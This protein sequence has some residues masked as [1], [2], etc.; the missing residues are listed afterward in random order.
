MSNYLIDGVRYSIDDGVDLNSTIA[1]I[2]SSPDHQK[3]MKP[4]EDE[5]YGK[6]V[7]TEG[8]PAVANVGM[9]IARS[10]GAGLIGAGTAVGTGS[11]DRGMEEF[12]NAM[13]ASKDA[14][15]GFTSPSA[16]L[17]TEALSEGLDEATQAVGRFSERVVDRPYIPPAMH[18]FTENRPEQDNPLVRGAG[19]VASNFLPVPGTKLV[20][21]MPHVGSEWKTRQATTAA[22]A[23]KQKVLMEEAA[24]AAKVEADKVAYEK[25]YNEIDNT[26]R[27]YGKDLQAPQYGQGGKL[28]RHEDAAKSE[29]PRV[30]TDRNAG[31]EAFDADMRRLAQEFGPERLKEEARAKNI[32]S[33]HP[34][35]P[36]E[37]GMRGDL[38][39][40]DPETGQ[41]IKERI[42]GP[43]A[44]SIEESLESEMARVMRP[45]ESPQEGVGG[46]VEHRITPETTQLA[47]QQLWQKVPELEQI[48]L[49][50]KPNSIH[51]DIRI[52]KQSIDKVIKGWKTN[53]DGVQAGLKDGW[54][55][56]EK[57]QRIVAQDERSARLWFEKIN[58]LQT[59]TNQ[60][61][62]K[63]T[64]GYSETPGTNYR[65]WKGQKENHST[66]TLLQYIRD[67]SQIPYYREVARKLLK[68]PV[69]NP[70]FEFVDAHGI[71][72]D[73]T[74]TNEVGRAFGGIYRGREYKINIAKKSQGHESLML[75]EAIHAR[76]HSAIELLSQHRSN[77][78]NLTG[79]EH[80]RP[81]VERLDALYTAFKD[82]SHR[83]YV[84]GDNVKAG[85]AL[86]E[87]GVTNVHE[88]IA[89]GFTN[90]HFQSY[91]ART[92]LPKHIRRHGWK[93]YWDS[94]TATVSKLLGFTR[95][96]QNFLSELLRAGADIME[97]ADTT[98][99]RFWDTSERGVTHSAN[100]DT[101]S[102]LVGGYSLEDF[103]RDLETKGTKLAPEVIKAIYEKQSGTTPVK[104]SGSSVEPVVKVTSE[105]PGLVKLQRQMMETRSL[106]ELEPEILAAKDIGILGANG[107]S[108]II[109]GDYMAKDH[110]VLSWAS[111]NINRIKNRFSQ[112]ANQMLHGESKKH[113][114]VGSYNFEWSRLSVQERVEL[115]DLGQALNNAQSKLFRDGIQAKAR[116]LFGKELTEAQLKSYEDRLRINSQVLEKINTFLKTEGKETINELPHYWSPAEFDGRFLAI[117]KQKDGT[118][119]IVRGS[120]LRP[121]EAKLKAAFTNHDIKIVERGQRASMD[122]D[123][124]I[125]ILHMLNKELRDPAS[126]AIAEGYRRLGFGRH[127]LKREGA[128]GALGTEGGRKG[129][130]RYEEVSEKYIRQSHE[131]LGSRELDKI[132]NELLEFEPAKKSPYAQA[133]AL[134][135]IDQARGGMNATMQA[136]SESVGK[137]AAG[138][139]EGV[140]LG[141]VIPPSTIIRDIIRPANQIK[142]TLL[143][144]F[145]NLQFMAANMMQSTYAIPKLLGMGAEYGKMGIL[146][147]PFTAAKAMVKALGTMV[148]QSHPDIKKLDS[149]GTFEATMK[150]DW[151][152]YASDAAK[153]KTTIRDHLSGMSTNA[154]IE[155]HAVRKPAA[156]MFLEMLRELGYDKV[157][158]HPDDIY[159]LT[160]NLTEDYM[161]SMQRHKKPHIFGRTGLAGTVA[162]P[163]QSFTT[164]WVA[165]LREYTKQAAKT[166]QNPANALPLG[167]FLALNVLTAGLIGTIGVKEWDVMAEA[168]N[169]WFN[170]DIPTG[171][172]TILKNSKS[173]KLNFGVLSDAAGVHIGATFSAPTM[174]GTGAPGV[175]FIYDA[176]Q[177]IFRALKETGVFGE[178]NKPTEAQKRDSLKALTPRSYA[179]GRIEE[180]YTPKGAPL[181]T[182]KG[183]AGP[184]TRTE[185]DKTA[186]NLGM[187]SLDEVKG[188]IDQYP[189]ER[190]IKNRSER[191]K[192]SAGLAVDAL[193]NGDKPEERMRALVSELAKDKYSSAEIRE[194]LKSQ[195]KSKVTEKDIRMMGHGTT[196]RQKLIIQMYNEL[197]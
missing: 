80:L 90:P 42:K 2:R 106:K 62:G 52:L 8:L 50:D 162:S 29:Y 159:W 193:L 107:I 125:Q 152:T 66:R 18:L 51:N 47:W 17:G 143:L 102:R 46:D 31:Q 130:N 154:A 134:E 30:R 157:A 196:T 14:L 195:L 26:Q 182:Q 144:G 173:D 188:K 19:E 4:V 187:Y 185:K 141:K 172:E 93:N 176:G 117:I 76:T 20:G 60:L 142:S 171:T 55:D 137:V 54:L 101:N 163:L 112:E 147:T 146:N 111:S 115:N 88:F 73:G 53:Q 12:A 136:L 103:K 149:I 56:Q 150:Y 165:Q 70:R 177:A 166:H 135:S 110:P 89:E 96:S 16:K 61:L 81:A 184:Y 78:K 190:K 67:G 97:G 151:S 109:N 168:L 99:R 71:S 27:P 57:A 3:A 6:R 1:A 82:Q 41:R 85:R 45:R 180:A 153:F 22:D 7:L 122:M 13:Q 175:G 127:G 83:L 48:A 183:S 40:Y 5:S 132:Y 181:Q 49:Q 178:M 120:Y 156:L 15:P 95:E 148:N 138:L 59:K 92:V 164:T 194:A 10:A 169:H 133:Y 63:P 11:M 69:F 68:D 21:R 34:M 28:A 186:R 100:Y 114:S 35:E 118:G 72:T 33:W 116:E 155:S 139:V 43:E 32:D 128:S 145:L 91:L 140:T 74:P 119:T 104:T 108:K 161:V 174:T 64:G 84:R 123:Q 94:F 192:T 87:Y 179:W 131:Y 36:V 124:Y 126:R 65:L 105:V 25:A 24:K 121:N 77:L 170:M 160:K 38:P 197:R 191:L 98:H 167:S 39:K 9:D 129:L 23:T 44:T 79:F 158:K 75:H 37:P 189:V 113:P 86:N 58:D